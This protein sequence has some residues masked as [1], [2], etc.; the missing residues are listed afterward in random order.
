MKGTWGIDEQSSRLFVSSDGSGTAYPNVR[1][2]FGIV[3]ERSSPEEL[4]AFKK[5]KED[6]PNLDFRPTLS[7]PVLRVSPDES[8]LPVLRVRLNSSE[9]ELKSLPEN[10]QVVVGDVW[11]PIDLYARDELVAALSGRGLEINAALSAEDLAWLIWESELSVELTGDIEDLSNSLLKS[12]KSAFRPDN[13]DATLYDYQK[14]G[15]AFIDSMID[16][17]LGVLLADEMGLGKTIQA[18][19][20]IQSMVRKNRRPVLVIVTAANLANWIREI[21]KFAPDLAISVHAG[22]SRAGASQH[23]KFGDVLITT[24]QIVLRDVAFMT[25]IDWS[26]I[27]LDEAQNIKNFESKQAK[28][29]CNLSKKSAIAITGTPIENSLSDIWSIFQFLHPALLGTQDEFRDRFPDTNSAADLLSRLIAPFVVR[30]RVLEV[31]DD[32]PERTDIFVPVFLSSPMNRAYSE[33]RDLEELAALP[34][35]QALRQICAVSREHQF[36]SNKVDRLLELARGAFESGD[37]AIVFA[38]FTETID[39][40]ARRVAQMSP[41]IFV[42]TLDGRKSPSE[43]QQIID[44]FQEVQ[45]AA[46]LIANPKAAGVGLNIQAANYVF[47][48]NPEWNPALIAQASARAYRR[49]QTKKVFVYYLYYKGTVEEYILE[50]LEQKQG[51]QDAGLGNLADEPSEAQLLDALRLSPEAL[52]GSQAWN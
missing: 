36:D 21:E 5:L 23:I 16:K 11:F 37:K 1:E 33:V 41:G 42:E 20:V 40:L 14:S 15:A 12:T 25:E 4:E 50:K 52:E 6:L 28:A 9:S 18:I 29:V 46:V 45:G 2:I 35:V 31:A 48:F 7:F 47:H 49:G 38:S 51:L 27:V 13:L 34:K 43:R 26:L 32:L 17:S 10:D 30:R 8:G 22:S 19:Y 39:L 24:Y 3:F 44:V